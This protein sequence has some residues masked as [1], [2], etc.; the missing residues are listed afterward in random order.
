MCCFAGNAVPHVAGTRI[1]GRTAAGVQSL[2]YSMRLTVEADVA[3]ILPLPIAS[4]PAGSED[5]LNFVN[6][7][8]YPTFFED[9]EHA[10]PK[11]QML[12]RSFGAPQP[13]SLVVHSVGAFE[14]SFVPTMADFARLDARFTLAPDVWKQLPHY[15]DY[16]FA[17]FRLTPGTNK[18]IHPM[19]FR[20][21]TRFPEHV[22]FPTVHVH[23]GAVHETA[24]FDHTLYFQAPR[25]PREG[26][27]GSQVPIRTFVKEARCAALVDLDR[28]VIRRGLSGVHPNSDFFVEL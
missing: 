4:A 10:F 18:A 25:A 7:E 5:A 22:F 12:A 2:V 23:D 20:F 8:G 6:L 16:G 3:M 27:W 17:V 24:H 9:I 26:E 21:R 15:N 19:A 28:E 14:A 1:Y 11:P 13:A